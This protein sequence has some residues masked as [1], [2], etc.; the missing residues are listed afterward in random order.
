MVS[1]DED[2]TQQSSH[3][4]E[5]GEPE[6]SATPVNTSA[7]PIGAP[8]S[9][10]VGPSTDDGKLQI[11][12]T[13]RE[14]T[15][16]PEYV[17]QQGIKK[18]HDLI[19]DNH[20]YKINVNAKGDSGETALHVAA[21]HGL[22]EVAKLLVIDFEADI[23]AEDNDKRQPLHKACLEGHRDI[24]ELLLENNADIE[25]RQENDATPL[26]EACWKGHLDVVE[27]LLGRGARVLVEDDD[28][29]SPLY[30]ASFHGQSEV[31]KRL[32]IA[33]RSNINKQER[34]TNKTA[35]H[36]AISQQHLAVVSELLVSPL[37]VPTSMTSDVIR[38]DERDANGH[39]PLI[40]ACI[41]GF[42]EGAKLL[43]E[44][45]ADCNVHTTSSG[46]TPLIIASDWVRKDIVHELL[47][48]DNI[49]VN[50]KDKGGLTALHHA[51]LSQQP[52]IVEVLIEI[53]AIDLNAVD[54][55]M[56]TPLH[57]AAQLDDERTLKL[58]AGKISEVDHQ[59][60]N[61][62]TALHIA[63]L[64]GLENHTRVLLDKG[65]DTKKGD[66]QG[67][68][69]LHLAMQQMN[70]GVVKSLTERMGE[71][72]QQDVNGQTALHLAAAS[73]NEKYTRLLLDKRADLSIRDNNHQTALHIASSVDGT[74]S[75]LAS[76]GEF[77][78]DFG[79]VIRLLL[80][81]GAK[82]EEKRRDSKT[83]TDLIL[84]G[85]R[86]ERFQSLLDHSCYH[87][88][89]EQAEEM[90]WNIVELFR[91]PETIACLPLFISQSSSGDRASKRK[92]LDSALEVGLH[93][94]KYLDPEDRLL[95]D[96][97][98]VILCILLASPGR[99]L[100]FSR[101]LERS[102]SFLESSSNHPRVETHGSQMQG[103]KYPQRYEQH[104]E[105]EI[106][107]S[108]GKRTGEL[109]KET[110]IDFQ[111]YLDNIK[112]ILL[113][114]S[115]Y[116]RIHIG[117]PDIFDP[118]IVNDGHKPLVEAF[119]ATIVQFFKDED[120]LL[121]LR[122]YRSVKDVIY[123]EGPA[124]IMSNATEGS[125]RM[126]RENPLL[127]EYGVSFGSPKF[128][129]VHLPATNMDWMDDLASKIMIKEKHSAQQY[130]ELR[131]FFKDSWV[132]IPDGEI[133]S[134][135]MKPRAVVRRQESPTQ[136]HHHATQALLRRR[137][138]PILNSK[139]TTYE[140]EGQAVDGTRGLYGP[141]Q[142]DNTKAQPNIPATALYMPFFCF[143]THC[144]QMRGKEKLWDDY[145]DLLEGYG[146]S[147]IH[148]SPTLD[149]WYYHFSN[150]RESLEDRDLRNQGQVVSKSLSEVANEP[151]ERTSRDTK[152]KRITILRVNQIWIWTISN[153][154]GG[155]SSQPASA[156][157]MSQIIVDY[158]I[159]AYDRKPEPSG[160]KA[161]T[162]I[163]Q[164]FS[165]YMNL[166]GRKES[167]LSQDLSAWK[168]GNGNSSV[169]SDAG[170]RSQDQVRTTR[171]HIEEAQNLYLLIKDVRD[172]LNI[173][174]SV[175]RFQKIVQRSLTSNLGRE[176]QDEELSADYVENDISEMDTI[177]DRIQSAQNELAN[178]Q[179]EFS[180]RISTASHE[181]TTLATEQT[182]LATEQS[183]V[184]MVFTF[185]TLLFVSF[186]TSR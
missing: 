171:K 111:R 122:R 149:E 177:A 169:P 84:A 174:K 168:S 39:T 52:D 150:D 112:D 121:T 134:R 152:P 70:E 80:S 175:S 44:A 104:R 151:V 91:K 154:Y 22:L 6:G 73:G 95:C 140:M 64:C 110:N 54:K 60:N 53:T 25:A 77:D 120:R 98:P 92:T 161:K 105:Q 89:L 10:D 125:E 3:G 57:L 16:A 129:W 33:S 90:D 40:I 167:Q 34:E 88:R 61:G 18:L 119:R 162:S 45:G 50:A 145:L 144:P 37:G 147:V 164:I 107:K 139:D 79:A 82:L 13:V 109:R 75:P 183:K 138:F 130:Y 117:S 155:I 36:A 115:S 102:L 19:G 146:N 143:S 31:V 21:E 24:A 159:D 173:L 51:C 65:A 55:D 142:I 26:D 116:A 148:G 178:R 69:P 2:K 106:Q 46:S 93:V 48:E 49:E 179:A 85:R 87:F 100:K 124:S 76:E 28:G 7:E 81:K 63:A 67:Q 71:I 101:K 59:D 30:S 23:S 99:D 41:D 8:G 123:G 32:L 17:Q 181:Q 176:L 83:A 20:A 182:T 47:K 9:G 172:E 11:L 86:A 133:E 141:K 165:G 185:A 62:Q 114:P 43:I 180:N 136:G 108:K 163:A 160:S 5:A 4:S 131:S 14:M 58:L 12:E 184:L 94:L 97:L 157:D 68:T 166:L 113:D 72:G 170:D 27:L 153:K 74:S 156:E 118:K 127:N 38:L 128:T 126:Q 78:Q 66:K 15:N 137:T 96:R 56:Q 186:P 135:I 35:L 158:C 1:V 29:W 103:S 42:T 132:Q